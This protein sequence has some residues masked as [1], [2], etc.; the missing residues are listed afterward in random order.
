MQHTS[1]YKTIRWPNVFIGILGLFFLNNLVNA[2]E[3]VRFNTQI[4]PLLSDRCFACH[5]PDEKQRAADLRLD[6]RH[7]AIAGDAG[8]A[9][10]VPGRPADSL[11]LA[12][13][14][15]HDPAEVMPPPSAKRKPFTAAEVAL[16]SRWIEQGAKYEDHWAFL[17]L[18]RPAPPGVQQADWPRGAE[19]RFLLAQ[20][21]AHQI[22]PAPVADRAVLWRRVALDLTGLP[23]DPEKLT[24]Y[25]ADSAPDAYERWVDYLL[26]S[27]HHGERWGRHWL[28]QARYADSNGYSIDGERE[29]WP[30]RDWVIQALNRDLPFHQFTIEQLA[31]DLLPQPTKGQQVAT[32][33][34]RNTLINQEGGSDREQFRVESVID[35]VNTTG[36]VWLGLTIGCAQCH[37][38]KFDPIAHREYYQLL[39]FFNST[40]D[41]NDRGPVVSVRRGELFDA[42]LPEPTETP[43]SPVASGDQSQP[44]S[45]PASQPAAKPATKP[46]AKSN[47]GLANVMVMRERAQPRPTFLLTRGDFTRPDREQGVMNPDVPRA[48]SPALPA[49]ESSRNRLT[50]AQWLVDAKNPLTPRVTVNRIW[51]RYFG[52]GLVETEEDFGMQGTPPTHPELLDWLAA[53]FVEQGWSLKQLHRRIVTT[54]VYRQSSRARPELRELDP[55]NLWLARQERI[56]L[57]GEVVRD[58]ALASSGLLDRAVGGPSVRPPQPDGVYAFTQTAKNW[59]T[60]TGGDRYR[61]GLYTFFFRSSPYP[62]L[63]TFDAPD[64]QTVCTRRVRSNTPLQSLTL[65]N[66][67]AFLEIA[68]GLARRVDQELA[69]DASLSARIER[70]FFWTQSRLPAASEQQ[71]LERFA[72]RQRVLFAANS[73]AAELLLGDLRER[74]A[75]AQDKPARSAELAT[76][77]VVARVLFNTDSFITRE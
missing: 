32:G 9:A 18:T 5:G 17:P 7:F 23:P 57:E 2:Q 52:R 25:L 19:D 41:A 72:E 61:R 26:Q 76:L 40:E 64:F 37:S 14:Q 71:L 66:D 56:R 30:Y 15:S 49:T 68:R 53:E 39:A 29:M 3:S 20:L 28:D 11:L 34:H 12:R 50:L 77:V 70:A 22:Q 74:V 1:P 38:H 13:I 62:L 35:R 73:S 21:E 36:A 75:E 54:A 44:A 10:I 67:P 58:A 48:V 47:P 69:A 43:A 24:E 27:P 63:T 4:R 65:A 6:Q 51:M 59:T 46:A 42:A 45:K 60:S 16:L 55:R 31:G 33:F 8:K